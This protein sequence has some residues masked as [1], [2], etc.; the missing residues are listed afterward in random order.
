MAQ[1]KIESV[2]GNKNT[3]SMRLECTSDDCMETFQWPN[4]NC[5]PDYCPMCGEPVDEQEPFTNPEC[6]YERVTS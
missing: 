2:I 1:F 3:G 4:R 6:H 5:T